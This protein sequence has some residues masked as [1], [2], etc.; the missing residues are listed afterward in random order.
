MSRDA[1]DE[2][3]IRHIRRYAFEGP[4]SLFELA[5][6]LA[7]RLEIRNQEVV[8]WKTTGIIET[9]R[10]NELIAQLRQSESDRDRANAE[11]KRAAAE[12]SMLMTKLKKHEERWKNIKQYLEMMES[13]WNLN[14]K[15]LGFCLALKKMQ[16]L[17]EEDGK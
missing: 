15:D 5:T 2:D 12:C 16:Q 9:K 11:W 14:E 7:D 1:T 6:Q 4:P 17:E 8:I 10:M 3:L 13:G